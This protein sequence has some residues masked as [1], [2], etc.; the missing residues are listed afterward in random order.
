MYG[1]TRESMRTFTG[2]RFRV[3][4]INAVLYI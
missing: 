1:I 2:G 3:K 4:G